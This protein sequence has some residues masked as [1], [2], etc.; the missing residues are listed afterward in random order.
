MTQRSPGA[1]V[2]RRRLGSGLRSSREKANI[3]IEAAARE[4]ECS[5]AKISRL[6]NGLGPARL[7]DVR[8]L[9]SL[10]GVEDPSVR[11]TYEDWARE[12]KSTSWWESDADLTSDDNDRYFAAETEA[13][14]VRMYCTPVLPALLQTLDYAN[15]HLR[16]LFPDWTASD[17]ERFAAMRHA[18]QQPVLRL[19]DPLKFEAVV[20]EAA[21][22]RRVGSPSV[23]VA[24][25]TWLADLLDKLSVDHRRE[26]IFRVVPSPLVPV[27]D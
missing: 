13:A 15:A 25:L 2:V 6:E 8:I 19:E 22:R 5:P 20:D 12:S 21:I 3:R 4:L 16:I 11:R 26:V 10:Y 27:G 24:Q 17:I 14:R 18:R 7:W 23:H 9:L 1:H